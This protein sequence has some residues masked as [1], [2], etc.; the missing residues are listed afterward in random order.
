MP[1]QQMSSDQFA[2]SVK[3]KYPQY[4]NIDNTTLTQK[5]IAKF[6]Q[7]KSRVSMAAPPA[8]AGHPIPG[9][10]TIGPMSAASRANIKPTRV[11]QTGSVQQVTGRLSGGLQSALP[12]VAAGVGE[13]YGGPAG[14]AVGGAVGKAAE[15]KLD[16]GSVH[17][18]ASLGEGALQGA[19]S[20][21]PGAAK[22]AG[23]VLSD[24]SD[25]AITKILGLKFAKNA[26]LG[27]SSPEAIKQI[28]KIVSDHVGVTASLGK[29]ASR[30][31]TAKEALNT[32]T[33]NIVNSA[34]GAKLVPYGHMLYTAGVNAID[35]ARAF[36]R[37]GNADAVDKL[38]DTLAKKF[39]DN[40]LPKDAL[41]LRRTLLQE[42]D[43]AGQTLWPP[44][45]RDFRKQLYHD[46]NRGIGAALPPSDAAKFAHNNLHVTKLITAEDALQ[47]RIA[48]RLTGQEGAS[49]G[50]RVMHAAA[51]G[52]LPTAGA[53]Y[54]YHET[55]SVKGAVIGAA[56]GY[57]ATKAA[58][59]TLVRSAGAK[60][61]SKLAEA[62]EK[63]KG[64]ARVT[65]QAVRAYSAVKDVVSSI[66]SRPQNQP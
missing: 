33:E 9:A 13:L 43:S 57:G 44:G 28:A 55:H 49:I 7:Y 12:S 45:T 1:E 63:L 14:A 64:P 21:I 25:K 41:K 53:A 59:S 47:E 29:F 40:I 35:K 11:E 19:L 38:V 34:V 8:P 51:H 65:P 22:G 50:Q 36:G 6:P 56:A 23:K 27:R 61:A 2:E 10:A 31:S 4:K 5:M 60:T 20:L 46:L 39:P 16:T 26:K 18:G 15:S 48:K 30:L 62:A 3:A 17:V 58:E 54:G 66:Q 24:A 32:Q 52:A 37:E 42:T